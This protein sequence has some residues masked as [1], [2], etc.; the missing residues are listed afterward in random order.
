MPISP[1][2]LT[3]LIRWGD[4]LDRPEDVAVARDGRVFASDRRFGAREI[5]PDATLKA[6]GETARPGAAN[7]I[8]FDLEGR[9][10]IANYGL[11]D[12]SPGPLERLDLATGRREVLL[13]EVDGR[14]LTASN[15]PLIDRAGNIWCSNSTSKADFTQAAREYADDGFIY[16]LRP[17]GAAAI[18][19]EGLQFA[20]GL[21]LSADQRYLFCCQSLASNVLRYPILPGPRL[22][23]GEPYCPQLGAVRV[24][25]VKR[26]P[27]DY[28]YTDGCALDGEGNLWVTLFLAD[29]VVAITP[30]GEVV[31]VISDPAGA[32][33]RAPTNV[34][35]GGADLCDVYIGSV[36]NPYVLKGR[37][38]L[39]GVELPHQL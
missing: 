10:L 4:G 18:V 6:V 30:A 24:E 35:F 37:S 2:P 9:L 25:G 11:E 39:A 21:A 19:A 12:G 38:P 26:D 32:V 29:K 15:Y 3:A 33:M 8:S 28:G 23:P 31:T 16:V 20:N 36:L 1:I 22:G 27:R 5:L 7:G 17:D 14:W 34:T 13:S